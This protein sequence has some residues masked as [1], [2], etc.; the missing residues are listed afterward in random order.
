MSDDPRLL[1][2]LAELLSEDGP[3]WLGHFAPAP[4]PAPL[5]PRRRVFRGDDPPDAAAATVEAPVAIFH[6]VERAAGERR[7]VALRLVDTPLERGQ[8]EVAIA[9]DWDTPAFAVGVTFP[10]RCR[11]LLADEALDL[12]ASDGATLTLDQT[13]C[14]LE[15]RLGPDWVERDRR[16]DEVLAAVTGILVMLGDAGPTPPAD[17]PNKSP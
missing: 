4:A 15:L 11:L 12:D 9:F 6:D 13:T 10:V 1:D 5:A 7:T 8:A 16:P 2:A 17:R 3:D 14:R